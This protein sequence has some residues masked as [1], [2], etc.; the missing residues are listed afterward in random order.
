MLANPEGSADLLACH[1][2]SSESQPL[3]SGGGKR[4][5]EATKTLKKWEAAC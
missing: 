5:A 1:N 2:L 3:S 4:D